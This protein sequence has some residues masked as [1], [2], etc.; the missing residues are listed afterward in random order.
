MTE[1][2]IMKAL[3]LCGVK[4]QCLGCVFRNGKEFCVTA[5]LK[6]TF[7]LINRKNAEIERARAEAIKDVFAKVKG[8]SNKTDFI[9]SGALVRREYTITEESLDQIAKEITGE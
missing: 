1:Q 6:Q 4:R 3:E 8:S 5:L 2:E 9:W 7:D